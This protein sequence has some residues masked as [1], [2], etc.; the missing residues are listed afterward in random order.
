MGATQRT[1]P[2]TAASR[3][4]AQRWRPLRAA[5]A[6]YRSAESRLFQLFEEA[7]LR[8][9]V[10]GALLSHGIDAE[11][12]VRDPTTSSFNSTELGRFPREWEIVRLDSVAAIGSGVT[13]G[14]DLTGQ[15]TV[16]LPY[17]RVANVQSGFL[18]LD[19]IKTVRVRPDEV[20]NFKLE[21]GDILM[22]EGG[23]ID[24][25]GRGAIW[26]GVI[27]PGL[28]QNHIFRVR[29]DRERLDP[30]FLE[31][32]ICSDIGR[33]YFFR[34]AKRTTNLA[35]INKTQLKAF[36][37]PLPPIREQERIAAA[38]EKADRQICAVA[39]QEELLVELKRGLMQ[40]LLTGKVRVPATVEVAR[41]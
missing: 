20:D 6:D 33:R 1:E 2:T 30:R 12:S 35:S 16:E 40:D 27:D 18:N 29:A 13:L 21:T 11:G 41:S 39:R 10:L 17:L 26:P 3:S 32:V 24:K 31:A 23:D 4:L 38:L 25:L 36:R 7:G 19:E 37:L 34:I 8:Q 14:K 9:G 22:T 28:H 15:P 5:D